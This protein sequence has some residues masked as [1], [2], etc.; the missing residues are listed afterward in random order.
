MRQPLPPDYT[1]RCL[2]EQPS[3]PVI[4]LSAEEVNSRLT[5]IFSGSLLER[6]GKRR[7][8]PFFKA[9]ATV[10]QAMGVPADG[11]IPESVFDALCAVARAHSA[12][13]NNAVAVAV[14]ATKP[15]WNL[16]HAIRELPRIHADF[17]RELPG[18]PL[19]V[20]RI[21][22]IK[23]LKERMGIEGTASLSTELIHIL[24]SLEHRIR[25]PLASDSSKIQRPPKPRPK[26]ATKP[27]KFRQPVQF[28]RELEWVTPQFKGRCQELP[29][30]SVWTGA[31]WDR[32][33]AHYR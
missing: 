4:T 19:V 17:I 26:S 20:A 1:R 25:N 24:L 30:R 2:P 28:S 33:F 5:D 23:S 8:N 32:S 16:E 9:L 3:K 11:V 15:L 29:E 22:C 18:R 14:Q 13:A 7:Q 12:Q 31:P 21:A 6:N 10:K 27:R